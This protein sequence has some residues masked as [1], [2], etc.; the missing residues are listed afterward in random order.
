MDGAAAVEPASVKDI[1]MVLDQEGV[2]A[3]EIVQSS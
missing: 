1:P 2:L 3:D